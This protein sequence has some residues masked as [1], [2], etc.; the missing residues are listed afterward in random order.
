MTS[1]QQLLLSFL[2]IFFSPFW[3]ASAVRTNV[4][5]N[6]RI[7]LLP[8]SVVTPLKLQ[9]SHEVF[10]N[11]LHPVESTRMILQATVGNATWWSSLKPHIEASELGLVEDSALGFVVGL[12][13]QYRQRSSHQFADS[14]QF[15][16]DRLLGL[17]KDPI[18][19][20]K[21]ECIHPDH[22]HG[23]HQLYTGAVH[24]P[25]D[26]DSHS[27]TLYRPNH[28]HHAPREPASLNP[29]TLLH[30]VSEELMETHAISYA[31]DC[32]VLADLYVSTDGPNWNR[33]NW[34][35]SLPANFS[36]AC[37]T[38]ILGGYSCDP[39]TGRIVK[40]DLNANL[41][42]GPIPA[43]LENLSLLQY[44]DLSFNQ[45]VGVIP[46][47]IGS[48]LNKLHRLDLDS[49]QLSGSIPSSLG[50]LA[51]LQIL[52]LFSNQLTGSIPESLGNLAQLEILAL[53]SNHL[54]GSIPESLGNLSL[55]GS[56]FLYSNQLTGSIPESLGNLSQLRYLYLSSN[57]L[58]G[59]IPESLGNLSQLRYLY[60]SSN[61]LT[62]SIP[63]SLGNLSLLQEFASSSNQLT[64]SIPASLGYLPQLQRMDLSS[65]RLSGSIPASID[66]LSQILEL[67]LSS[68]Q[69]TGRIP[70]SIGNL[71][72]LQQLDLSFNQLSGS[73]P[74]SLGNL[75][76]LQYL[77]LQYN[78]LTGSIPASLGNLLFL[79]Q[80]DL[81]SNQLSGPIPESLGNLSLLRQ[82][83]LQSNQLSGSIP[84]SLANL[85]VLRVLDFHENNLSGFPADLC[86][87]SSLQIVVLSNNELVEFPNCSS[88]PFITLLLS[89]N[90]LL[91][92]PFDHVFSWPSLQYLDVSRNHLVGSFPLV[93]NKV[94]LKVLSLAHNNFTG[95]FPLTPC[96]YKSVDFSSPESGLLLLDVSGN[97]ISGF[98]F[99]N[100][101]SGCESLCT[102]NYWSLTTLKLSAN[103]LLGTATDRVCN[104]FGNTWTGGY[105]PISQFLRLFPSLQTL[106][107]SHNHLDAPF[108]SVFDLP[109]IVS[110][111]L[112]HNP[113]L[114][115]DIALSPL[116]RPKMNLSASSL[117]AYS[118]NMT[119]YQ[120]T[121]GSLAVQVDPSFFAFSNCQCRSGYYGK[122]P[123]CRKCN[124]SLLNAA[125]SFQSDD[126]QSSFSSNPFVAWSASGNIFANDGYYASP[127]F[128]YRQMVEN[129]GYPSS[130]QPC[131]GAGTDE[132][133]CKS[134]T[135]G[136]CS[137]GY[138]GRLCSKCSVGF[139]QSGDSCLSCP[140]GVP[141]VLFGMV[142]VLVLFGLVV[143]SFF[144]GTSAS[145]FAKI[146]V[147]FSQCLFFI[148]APMSSG[149]Y[150]TTH[151]GSSFAMMSLAGPKCFYPDWSFDTNYGVAV[152]NTL[153]FPAISG[154]IWFVGALILRVSRRAS[155]ARSKAWLDRCRRSALFLSVFLY[156]QAV[157]AILAPL[158]C[159]R[160][161][162]DH[163]E[164]LIAVPYHRCSS[165]LRDLSIVL[166]LFYVIGGPVLL[167]WIVSRSG[168]T[169]QDDAVSSRRRYVYSLLFGSYRAECRWWELI[170]T[171][172]RVLFVSAFATV[173]SRSSIQA[174][175][176]L[177]VLGG[178]I[179]LSSL[180][181]PFRS[182]AENS[183]ETLSLLVLL[184]NF[185]IELKSLSVGAVDVETVGAVLF[186]LNT[187]TFAS[188]VLA[189]LS[190][191]WRSVMD[192]AASV[193][194]SG[195]LGVVRKGSIRG[196]RTG[197]M[198]RPSGQLKSPLL[199]SAE[200]S[201][202]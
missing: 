126:A 134:S 90:Q 120:S 131:R 184:I 174:L 194:G 107:V 62:G 166:L 139:F 147:F 6:G 193:I 135:S 60:L 53:Y 84:A 157:N 9:I 10:G 132:T 55:L 170:V 65:N 91:S 173:Q 24:R 116:N 199:D 2:F 61:Q 93:P 99:G 20:Q 89:A 98:A 1:K 156:M 110:L 52:A 179:L 176:V 23:D 58:T 146:I 54:T 25:V 36:A 100:P 87:A 171:V 64:G 101:V 125:C 96:G 38:P 43:T 185:G 51:Q 164:Y 21:P 81:Q 46:E 115:L 95:T 7:G 190:T 161:E 86:T 19:I 57:Q 31:P 35:P 48:R 153:I 66:N 119:C 202:L 30:D 5:F 88:A 128:S 189:I 27:N 114:R 77:D 32:A 37:C 150:S 127:S 29:P 140:S 141:L 121:Y 45:L 191:H 130:I 59:S 68:N 47:A 144:V 76:S 104:F 158:A 129:V 72:Q 40:I 183:L 8:E 102:N 177:M 181:S 123:N 162:G 41:L 186:A 34:G 26:T 182:L 97:D 113:S 16:A 154:L 49:N 42:S 111:D 197:S 50:N 109:Q 118:D 195:V 80:L 180:F 44:L 69:M 33:I 143:W 117:Y 70:A 160:D 192:R 198:P 148:R 85:V 142:I 169:T 56:L 14:K 78:Q 82:L 187:V 112:T 4:A 165:T 133:P 163:E 18:K 12:V 94:S 108:D 28:A 168:V 172:R 22:V 92:F 145:G 13:G 73:I 74:A 11:S 159:S 138:E 137:N 39:E 71:S 124:G 67:D 79:L 83:Y 106:D 152:A 103:G 75:L 3:L 105:L 149:L 200:N 15:N 63:E 178:S 188:L 151:S 196:R 155:A 167:A 136:P 122:P 175:L 17:T 201:E